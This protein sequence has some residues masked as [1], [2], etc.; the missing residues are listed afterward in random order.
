MSKASP[1]QL[2]KAYNQ[3]THTVAKTRQVVMLYDGAI[4]FLSQ[5]K[6]AIEQ[7]EAERRYKTL[8][9]AGEIIMG[10]QSCLDFE[11]GETTAQALFDFYSSVDLRILQLHRT[12]DAQACEQIIADLR[13]MR[14]V[15]NQ[16]DRGDTS[17]PTQAAAD[18]GAKPVTVSA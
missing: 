2:Y 10:L 4:R 8:T 7:G 3:A 12:Q 18:P 5:A 6:E 13:D 9:R 1:G 16:I 14:E 11:A 15:W 17:E